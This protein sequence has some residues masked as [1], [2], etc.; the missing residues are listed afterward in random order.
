MARNQWGRAGALAGQARAV[1]RA[2]GI[3]DIYVTPLVCAV[4]ARAAWQRGDVPAA[5][6]ELVTAQRLRYL[7]TYAVPHVAVQARI[8]AHPRAPRAGRPGR[9]QD[10][11]GGDR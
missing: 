5:R 4:Q 3:E 9:G 1:L 6:G 2:A 8:E 7:L 11:D 10:A